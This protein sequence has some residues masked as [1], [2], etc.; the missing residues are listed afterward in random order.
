[1]LRVGLTGSIAVGK[2]FVASVLRE[3]GCHVIDA[4][5]IARAVVAP[6]TPGL[7]AIIEEF[8]PEFLRADGSLDRGR[9]AAVVFADERKRKRLNAILHPLIIA[10]QEERLKAL[11]REDPNGIAVVEA[12]LLVETGGYQRFD[13]LI[14]VHCRPEIQRERLM[15]RNKLTR[16]EAER[17]IAAQMAQEEKMRYADFLIDTSNGFEDTRRQVEEVYRRLRVLAGSN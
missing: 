5:E 4:D 13:K 11:E 10:V 15:A 14:V 12:A 8:G 17:W 3:L 16:D 2:S 9:L 1:M 6:G 7:R